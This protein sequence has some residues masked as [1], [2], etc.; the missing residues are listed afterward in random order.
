MTIVKN[1]ISTRAVMTVLGGIAAAKRIDPAAAT[2]KPPPRGATGAQRRHKAVTDSGTTAVAMQWQR[3]SDTKYGRQCGPD[4]CRYAAWAF[5]KNAESEA[6]RELNLDELR[7]AAQE[8]VVDEGEDIAISIAA[9]EATASCL[10]GPRGAKQGCNGRFLPCCIV[11]ED[12][13][14][15]RS[16]NVLASPK[17]RSERK[18]TTPMPP[19]RGGALLPADADTGLEKRSR[20]QEP[21]EGKKSVT[22]RGKHF[23]TLR[24]VLNGG[25]DQGPKPM[26]EEAPVPWETMKSEAGELEERLHPVL[27]EITEAIKLSTT[28]KEGESKAEYNTCMD[29][30]YAVRAKMENLQED[31]T[32]R[33]KE[34]TRWVVQNLDE[35]LRWL[36][37]SGLIRGLRE[38]SHFLA[39]V[40]AG[41]LKSDKTK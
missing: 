25:Y 15:T 34:R 3:T 11:M 21:S 8:A 6:G 31:D 5:A 40:R 37:D 12:G 23:A 27:I 33:T 2:V 9:A 39:R 20:P 26:A 14:Q 7:S 24:G 36:H 16:G 32:K 38:E 22:F 19:P 30:L 41:T 13:T 1:E 35:T 29:R 18:R 17:H 28:V 4:A 10:R